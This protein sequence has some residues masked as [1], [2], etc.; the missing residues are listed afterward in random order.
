VGVLCKITGKIVK[1]PVGR[2][3]SWKPQCSEMFNWYGEM[4]KRGEK[5]GG[6]LWLNKVT[7]EHISCYT[8]SLKHSR[9]YTT[10]NFI[11]I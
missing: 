5:K 1:I 10:S 9:L 6:R 11:H 8:I 4:G 7:M 2:Y 3:V